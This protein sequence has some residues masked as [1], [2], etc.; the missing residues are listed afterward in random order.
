MSVGGDEFRVQPVAIRRNS[1]GDRETDPVIA[2]ART[3]IIIYG[4]I[5]FDPS[6]LLGVN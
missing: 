3:L 5:N 1:V 4:E 6:I 2:L